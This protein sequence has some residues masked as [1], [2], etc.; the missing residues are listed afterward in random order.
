MQLRKLKH[1]EVKLLAQSHTESM[2]WSQNT[3]SGLSDTKDH[4]LNYYN[5]LLP[6]DMIKPL[7]Q[8]KDTSSLW[9]LQLPNHCKSVMISEEEE[10][11]SRKLQKVKENVSGDSALECYKM[12]IRK[13]WVGGVL[14]FSPLLESNTRTMSERCKKR[15]VTTI[16]MY[17][18]MSIWA[19][20]Y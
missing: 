15:N 1:Q 8:T 10:S 17:N 5:L 7:V 16:Q 9:L 11:R 4:A 12:G 2:W 18:T 13:Q 6:C 20:K 19:D 14:R 3:D